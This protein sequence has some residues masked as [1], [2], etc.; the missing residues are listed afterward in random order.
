LHQTVEE[1][2]LKEQEYIRIKEEVETVKLEKERL[3]SEVRNSSILASS[4]HIELSADRKKN[5]I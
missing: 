5:S 3:T 1:A 4:K 2:H